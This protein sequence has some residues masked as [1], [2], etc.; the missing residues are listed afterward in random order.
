[1]LN[2][3]LLVTRQLSPTLPCG[4][5]WGPPACEP[6]RNVNW[7]EDTDM[8]PLYEKASERPQ[9]PEEADGLGLFLHMRRFMNGLNR[10]WPHSGHRLY[11]AARAATGAGQFSACYMDYTPTDP[12]LVLYEFGVNGVTTRGGEDH[13]WETVIYKAMRLE[14]KPAI[15]S[16]VTWNFCRDDEGTNGEYKMG[17]QACRPRLSDVNPD[18]GGQFLNSSGDA[19]AAVTRYSL[20]T[21]SAAV[22]VYASIVPFMAAKAK[23]F[24]P[25]RLLS[26]DGM[27]QESYHVHEAPAKPECCITIDRRGSQGRALRSG[28]GDMTE[29]RD[30]GDD[31]DEDEN[32]EMCASPP[33]GEQL[34]RVGFDGKEHIVDSR[35]T[36]LAFYNFYLADLMLFPLFQARLKPQ[37]AVLNDYP[38]E[39]A[40]PPHEHI[41][42]NV[43][44]LHCY[45]WE[46]PNFKVPRVVKN[47]VAKNASRLPVHYL[48]NAELKAAW[49]HGDPD[50][51]GAPGWILVTHPLDGPETVRNQHKRGLVSTRLGDYI[52]MEIDITRIT[53]ETDDKEN[54]KGEIEVHFLQ[55]YQH[56]GLARLTCAEGCA[57]DPQVLDAT[58]SRQSSEA[59][60]HA[61][62]VRNA[63]DLSRCHMSFENYAHPVDVPTTGVDGNAPSPG[64][65]GDTG[66]GHK[67]KLL[68]MLVRTF[69]TMPS[70]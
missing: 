58:S 66:S 50:D 39:D 70:S 69:R 19:T 10:T 43:I 48:E 7:N 62:E 33:K 46:H 22:S 53:D 12:D 44:D 35:V 36:K 54:A 1:M 6:Q 56:M 18:V 32:E 60:K 34:K 52:T 37:G 68:S 64:L 8:R 45:R 23:Y 42:G 3:V 57:C 17:R 63:G 67:F 49:P 30:D 27:H 51:P 5:C 61:F 24:W 31:G 47:V 38:S 59:T 28:A 13:A 40:I 55:S 20:T 14:S 15:I 29:M 16:V 41:L 21:G 25:P 65:V 2:N 4:G 11:N 9:P 26:I